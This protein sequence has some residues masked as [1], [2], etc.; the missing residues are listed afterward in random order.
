MASAYSPVTGKIYL[1]AGYSTG[2]VTSAQSQVWEYDPVANAFDSSRAPIP[3]ALGGAGSGLI[4]HRLYVAGGR[5]AANATLNS[6]WAYD[7]GTDTWHTLAP[8]PAPT[9]VP[10]SG[11]LSGRVYVW[12]GGNPFL[13]DPW[14]T[15]AGYSYDPPTNSWTSL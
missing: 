3:H 14:T 6:T 13:Q 2:Q 5:D 8:V 7:M 15:A 9:N 4:A 12:G 1:V 10:A 11:A